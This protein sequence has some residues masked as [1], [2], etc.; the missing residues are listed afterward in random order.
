MK[1]NV[2]LQSVLQLRELSSGELLKTFPLPVGTVTG[3]SGKKKHTEIFYHFTSFL[4]PGVIYHCDLTRT[5]LEPV[6]SEL[7]RTFPSLLYIIVISQGLSWNP[8]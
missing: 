4:S 5:E 1:Y 8:W 7:L 2:C 3:Y 6:V